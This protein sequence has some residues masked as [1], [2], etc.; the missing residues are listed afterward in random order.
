MS[1][2][3]VVK[4]DGPCGQKGVRDALLDDA[5]D[6]DAGRLK[7]FGR[8]TD[9]PFNAGWPRELSGQRRPLASEK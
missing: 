5:L 3:L 2:S 1:G 8:K 7:L 9:L 4:C 6:F